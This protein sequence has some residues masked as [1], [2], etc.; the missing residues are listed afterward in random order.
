MVIVMKIMLKVPKKINNDDSMEH[1]SPK[2][3]MNPGLQQ[4]VAQ[5]I[6]KKSEIARMT[7]LFTCKQSSSTNTL[8]YSDSDTQL[9]PCTDAL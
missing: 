1:N 9:G 6:L 4:Q 5:H 8:A 2:H 7:T 3:C